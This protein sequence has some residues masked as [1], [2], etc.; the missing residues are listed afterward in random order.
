MSPGNRV[1]RQCSLALAAAGALTLVLGSALGRPTI[2]Q[3]AAVSPAVALGLGIGAIPALRGY[4]FTLWIVAAVVAGMVFPAAV[5]GGGRVNLK[6]KW[7]ILIVI[8]LV[9]FG[10]G[11]QMSI[12][13]FAG[14][15]LMPK[16]V[17]VGILG[18]L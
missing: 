7:L 12:R 16:G 14:V 13:D 10:M 6:D 8:Q 15:V 4:Q 3:P 9:M 1:F 11:T 5:L 18:Q 2:W 17:V